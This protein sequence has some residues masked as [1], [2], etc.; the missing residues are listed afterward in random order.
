MVSTEEIKK[1]K[2]SVKIGKGVD[3]KYSIE[4]VKNEELDINTYLEYIGKKGEIEN[5]KKEDDSSFEYELSQYEE[6][7]KNIDIKKINHY[8]IYMGLSH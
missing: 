4:Q 3:Y 2:L 8:K 1:D 7:L 5:L 6:K